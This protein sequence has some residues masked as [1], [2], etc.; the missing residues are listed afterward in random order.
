MGTQ[1]SARAALPLWWLVL[2]AVAGAMLHVYEASMA[3]SSSNQG[4]IAGLLL[5]SILPFCVAALLLKFGVGVPRAAGYAWASLLGSMYMH[6]TVFVQPTSSTASLGLLFMPLWNLI[7]I[8][9]AGLFIAWGFQAFRRS[10]RS[11]GRPD[12]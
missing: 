6:A 12:A 1:T 11:D 7:L 8:G 3:E 9:P 4:F 2:P 10:S 5:W